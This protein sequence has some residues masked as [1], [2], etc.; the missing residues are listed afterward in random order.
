MPVSVKN[1]LEN[2]KLRGIHNAVGKLIEVEEKYSKSISVALGASTSN[3]VIDNEEK[4]KEA[5]NYL[6][7]N[8]LGRVT[9]YPLNIIKS[10]FVDSDTLSIVKNEDGYI[11]IASNLVKYD[12]TYKIIK[13][14]KKK[15]TIPNQKTKIIII[16]E[17]IPY[18]I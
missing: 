8:N 18:K 9:F 2:P 10:K 4:A 3:I 11:D 6:K 5:I 13:M 16:L 7:E 1:V 12:N 15:K 14:T 17:K